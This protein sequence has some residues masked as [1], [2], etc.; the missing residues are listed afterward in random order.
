MVV[1]ATQ[2]SIASLE[3][4]L[5]K[6]KNAALINIISMILLGASWTLLLPILMNPS[7]FTSR[8]AAAVTAL[9]TLMI[10]VAVVIVG[11]ILSLI[12]IF[13]FLVPAFSSL[14][15]YNPSRFGTPSKMIKVGYV[16]GFI[17]IVIAA[18]IFLASIAGAASRGATAAHLVFGGAIVT[19][20][21]GVI[22]AILLFIGQIGV[23]VGMFRLNDELH[24]TSLLVAGILFI[25][26]IFLGWLNFI[27]WI[28]VFVGARSALNELRSKLRAGTGEAPSEGMHL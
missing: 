12:S 8:A 22:G 23:I 3:R 10:S 14:R 27:G 9:G 15:E 11:A 7:L 19:L 20:A 28:L 21:L 13:A 4:G 17:L 25:I 26:G 6:L 16:G 5:G 24:K 2:V 18:I 1:P